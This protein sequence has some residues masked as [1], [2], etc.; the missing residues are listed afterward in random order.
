[1]SGSAVYHQHASY[2][3]A[4][5]A[6]HTNGTHNGAPWNSHNAG[7]RITKERF[8]NLIAWRDAP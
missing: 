5:F 7:T 8:D 1:M 3:T 6:V 2:G 4:A